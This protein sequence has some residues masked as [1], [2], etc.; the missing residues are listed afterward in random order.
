MDVHPTKNVSIGIDPYPYVLPYF[1]AGRPPRQEAPAFQGA[2]LEGPELQ[3][4]AWKV[5]LQVTNDGDF[6]GISWDLMDFNGDLMG[7]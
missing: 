6:H 4:L 2:G 1:Y 5:M 7:F 3:N